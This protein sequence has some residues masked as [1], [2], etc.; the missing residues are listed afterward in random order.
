M[1]LCPE[2]SGLY[3]HMFSSTGYEDSLSGL[4]RFYNEAHLYDENDAKILSYVLFSVARTSEI[5]G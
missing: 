5:L 4:M 3:I 1:N 2:S